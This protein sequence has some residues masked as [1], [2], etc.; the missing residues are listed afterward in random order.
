MK[1]SHADLRKDLVERINKLFTE[2]GAEYADVMDVLKRM[3]VTYAD[4]G[5]NLL[6][7][8]PAQEVLDTPRFVRD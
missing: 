5:Q 8:K 1:K 7:E 4:K 2:S 3:H 6:N